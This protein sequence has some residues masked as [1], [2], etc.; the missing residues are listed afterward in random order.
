MKT[1]MVCDLDGT[2]FDP[3]HRIDY[4]LARQWDD[5]HSRC[6]QDTI[7]TDVLELLLRVTPELRLLL[8]T[9]R[10]ANYRDKTVKMLT[11]YGVLADTLLMRAE[12]DF[13][14]APEMKLGMLEDFFGSK[15]KVLSSVAFCLDDHDG[16][17]E[18]FRNYGLPCWQVRTGNY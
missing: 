10:T 8:L 1:W 13:R 16:I 18:A 4:A 3:T 14:K 7:F 17:V 5:F 9:G 2:L 15:E 6:D 12:N 11:K